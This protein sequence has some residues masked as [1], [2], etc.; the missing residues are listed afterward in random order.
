MATTQRSFTFRNRYFLLTDVVLFV[1][2][3]FGSFVLR[4]ETVRV[5]DYAVGL[6]WFTAISLIVKLSLFVTGGVYSRYWKSAGPA[7]LILLG[8]ICLLAGI[9]VFGLVFAV[10]MIVPYSQIPLPRS[11]AII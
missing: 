8:R 11:V 6:L 10:T 4:L 9:A 3:A 5:N 1:A 2:S 7:E